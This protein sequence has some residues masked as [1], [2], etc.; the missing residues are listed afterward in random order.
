MKKSLYILLAGTALFGAGTLLGWET[1]KGSDTLKMIQSAEKLLRGKDVKAS[2]AAL[3]KL[4]K[5]KDLA[6]ADRAELQI[7]LADQMSKQ[8]PAMTKEAEAELDKVIAAKDVPAGIK[9]KVYNSRAHKA[10]RSNFPGGGIVYYTNGIEKALSLYLQAEKELGAKLSSGAKIEL[11]RNIANCYLELD[12]VEKANAVLIAATKLPDLKG[13]DY[14]NANVNLANVYRRQ[15]RM[16]LALPI[17]QKMLDTIPN[18]HIHKRAAFA[19][20]VVADIKARKGLDA[21]FEFLKKYNPER[22]RRYQLDNGIFDP[23]IKEAEAQLSDPKNKAPEKAFLELLSL[24]ERKGGSALR[25]Q[26]WKKYLPAVMKVSGAALKQHYSRDAAGQLRGLRHKKHFGGILNDVRKHHLAVAP[27]DFGIREL[28]LECLLRVGDWKGLEVS[29]KNMLKREKLDDARKI[30]YSVLLAT[31][32][33]KNGKAIAKEIASILK[34]AKDEK[35]HSASNIASNLLNSAKLALR[36]EREDVARA[37]WDAREAMLVPE[38]KRSLK[39]PFIKNGPRDIAGFLASD[40][41]KDPKNLGVLDR[42]YGNNLKFLLETDAATTG[43]V[44]TEDKDGAK[45]TSFVATCDETAVRLFF[46]MPCTKERA[47]QLRM[48]HGW[49]GGFE[50]YLATGY[51]Q[52]YTC[53]LIDCPPNSRVDDEFVTMYDNRFYRRLLAAHNN[54]S[55][56]FRIDDDQIL[57]LITIDWRGVMNGIPTNGF[58]WE[59]EPLHWERRGWSWG[60][61]KSVHNRSSFGDLIFDNMTKE[62]VTMI[63]RRLLAYAKKAYNA[64][65]TSRT[66]GLL[67]HWGDP[68]LGDVAFHKEVIAPFCKKYGAYAAAI[69]A[70]MTDE[71]VNRVY[72]E[73]Y[74]TLINTK[75][76]VEALRR[77]YVERKLV[78]EED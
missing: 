72:D 75:F 4:I 1:A 19:G 53:L 39:V 32:S 59:F 40:L 20:F 55:Y 36:M 37:L 41:I 6:P 73:A 62:N 65:L 42:K 21:A 54:I 30:R 31:V 61:S 71:E 76:V 25:D 9:L 77:D 10:F 67:E 46:M 18:L 24:S 70:D 52:P 29:L 51:D 12:Q 33:G 58:K 27:E 2:I 22:I 74:E 64:E 66:R 63:K 5:A 43:R 49:F 38:G 44:V 45:P 28:E 69:K 60:G 35:Q 47:A 17:Y 26:V 7:R 13:D 34:S 56:D 57:L 23:A 8:K 15:L 16:D 3:E 11:A 50:A 48:G 68:E 14:Y 78:E